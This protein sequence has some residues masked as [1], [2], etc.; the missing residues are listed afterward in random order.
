MRSAQ[1]TKVFFQEYQTE[2]IWALLGVVIGAVGWEAVR[3]TLTQGPAPVPHAYD[4][5]DSRQ[6]FEL[7]MAKKEELP[8]Y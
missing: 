7:L 5:L 4:A 3:R 8:H 6:R 2:I 1:E